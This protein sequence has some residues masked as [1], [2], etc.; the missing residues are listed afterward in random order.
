MLHAQVQSSPAVLAQS[1]DAHRNAYN[2]AFR[3]LGLGWRW[4]SD[5][6]RE[7]LRIPEERT[8]IGA[9]VQSQH[10]HMLKAYEI[11]FLS[12]LVYETKERCYAQL[13]ERA[14]LPRW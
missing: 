10:A 13:L 4:D 8:R 9:Y 3:E 6:Y 14:E 7:L 2:A 11:G 12:E 1:E 5:T